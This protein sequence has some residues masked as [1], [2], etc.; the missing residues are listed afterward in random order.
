MTVNPGARW[1]VVIYGDLRQRLKNLVCARHGP[2]LTDADANKIGS[3][4]RE[5]PLTGIS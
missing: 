1:F 2:T 4:F 3:K 5:S